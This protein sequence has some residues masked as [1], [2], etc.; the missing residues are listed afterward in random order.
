V[1]KIL[2]KIGLV[3]LIVI[4]SPFIAIGYVM[5]WLEPRVVPRL[6]W[7]RR[8]VLAHRASRMLT[9]VWVAFGIIAW[10][11]AEPVGWNI[12]YWTVTALLWAV[13]IAGSS[14]GRYLCESCAADFPLDAVAEAER[15]QSQLRAYHRY[16]PWYL[17]ALL[18]GLLGMSSVK[19]LHAPWWLAPTFYDIFTVA[20]CITAVRWRTVHMRLG[21]WCPWCRDDDGPDDD[22]E[23]EPVPDP[24]PHAKEPVS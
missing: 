6:P 8:P 14:H 11:P 19:L 20:V 18:V 13:L 12:A 15:K 22:D 23:F 9:A 21:P 3:T 5:V 17:A 16:A 7:N 10:L 1:N 2:K 24:D 4:F